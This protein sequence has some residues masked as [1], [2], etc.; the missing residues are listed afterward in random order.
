MVAI[1]TSFRKVRVALLAVAMLA[2]VGTVATSAS[3]ELVL[4]AYKSGT[5]ST[6]L[7]PIT[8]ATNTVAIDL[9]FTV[10]GTDGDPSN[11]GYN[12][13]FF[14]MYTSNN[15]VGGLTNI[16][17]RNNQS[18]TGGFS[19]NV[20]GG[21]P[22]GNNSYRGTPT[23][24]D[25]DGDLD[26]GNT[27]NQSSTD[28]VCSDWGNRTEVDANNKQVFTFNFS[29]EILESNTRKMA[30]IQLSRSAYS[31]QA[32]GHGI[33][34]IYAV[35]KVSAIDN[36]I[37]I[38]GNSVDGLTPQTGS[39]VTLYEVAAAALVGGETT[40]GPDSGLAT[41]DGTPSVGTMNHFLWQVRKQGDTGA[42]T[43]LLGD[44]LTLG[45]DYAGLTALG[46]TQ[47]DY[48][49]RMTSTYLGDVVLPGDN[50]S[51]STTPLELHLLP[52][53]GTLLLLIGGSAAMGWF[54]RRN[55]K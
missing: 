16:D 29:Q 21:I 51:T 28:W 50:A 13:I 40:V 7:I 48:D 8:A 37:M 26:L 34:Q 46:L 30:T 15:L 19:W 3:A 11:D 4:D 41:L 36:I 17:Y 14:N 45:V 5:T 6:T 22:F 39:K 54:R 24:L 32:M 42:W 2:L 44:A 10:N 9:W 25:G 53:P 31:A 33:T 27:D 38:D 18:Q 23:D 47:G 55:K 35:G 12:K 49:V 43:D 20:A 1:F 52:E